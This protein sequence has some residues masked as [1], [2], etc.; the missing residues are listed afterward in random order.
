MLL[1]IYNMNFLRRV[2]LS[3]FDIFYFLITPVY[4]Y[5]IWSFFHVRFGRSIEPI[6]KNIIVCIISYL[7]I[8]NFYIFFNLPL[9]TA[10]INLVCFIFISRLFIKNFFRQLNESLI[11][12]AF[13]ITFE[14]VVV[15]LLNYYT[16]DYQD[17]STY[18]SIIAVTLVYLIEYIFIKYLY[19]RNYQ[20]FHQK[21]HTFLYAVQF[22]VPLLTI[23]VFLIVLN[24]TLSGSVF[25]I[26]ALFFLLINIVLFELYDALARSFDLLT[27]QQT[28]KQEQA[29]Y[30][31]QLRMIES[32]NEESKQFRH[33]LK[34]RLTPLYGFIDRYPDTEL[35]SILR[36]IIPEN[37][38][39]PRVATGHIA[40]DSI[41]NS[42]L[43]S[44]LDEGIEIM[45]DI[46]VPKKINIDNIDLA[47]VL[48]NLLDNAIEGCLS[49]D[50]HRFIDLKIQFDN[51]RIKL[52]ISNAFD[53]IV[54]KQANRFLSRKEDKDIHGFGL[55]SV[56][57][58]VDK[59]SGF[60][61]IEYIDDVF[62][63]SMILNESL[64]E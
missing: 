26:I 21:K 12:L 64:T 29:E 33:D 61:S 41:I 31:N 32:H 2:S 39:E 54:N 10:S 49:V 44:I 50:N 46:T 24:T 40:I 37:L 27:E 20:P 23:I 4:I 25:M 60:Q 36:G 18:Q 35:E 43:N 38:K 47:V 5:N 59:Y 6:Y 56:Q 52:R 7:L 3:L 45:C 8:S 1:W 48:G 14:L 11:L 63:V 30:A 62:T 28:F 55:R 22:I 57:R 51:N 58:I 13:F 9:L 19:R 16:I 53:G 42:K 34:N 17:A 15:T